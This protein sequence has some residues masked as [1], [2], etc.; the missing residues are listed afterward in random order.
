[1]AR[2]VGGRVENQLQ[3]VGPRPVKKRQHKGSNYS[4]LRSGARVMNYLCKRRNQAMHNIM[5]NKYSEGFH[6]LHQLSDLALPN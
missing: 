5:K 2:S 3:R 1:M 4:D 6:H